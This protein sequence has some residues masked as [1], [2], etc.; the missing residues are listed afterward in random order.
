MLVESAFPDRLPSDPKGDVSTPAELVLFVHRHF[1]RQRM[2]SRRDLLGGGGAVVDFVVVVVFPMKVAVLDEQG[3]PAGD[4]AAAHQYALRAVGRNHHVR[5][6]GVVDV[7]G[8][9]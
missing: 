2:T 4:A 8:V 6:E 5:G 7:L 3:V 1:S 9:G